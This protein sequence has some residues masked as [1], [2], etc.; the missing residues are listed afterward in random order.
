[1]LPTIV[2]KIA[3][4][5]IMIRCLYVAV[6]LFNNAQKHWLD[7]LFYL[8]VTVVAYVYYLEHYHHLF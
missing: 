7:I 8:S 6:S 5:I 2:I 1:M 3:L 4:I